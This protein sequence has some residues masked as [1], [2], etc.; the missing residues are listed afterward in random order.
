MKYSGSFGSSS[1]CTT[2]RGGALKLSAVQFVVVNG[3]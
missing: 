2:T 3:S 1:T